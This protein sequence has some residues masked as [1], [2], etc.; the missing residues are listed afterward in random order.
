MDGVISRLWCVAHLV[1]IAHHSFYS[2]EP[3]GSTEEEVPLSASQRKLGN[4]V[5]GDLAGKKLQGN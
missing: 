3:S 1:F 4:L 5:K 2:A